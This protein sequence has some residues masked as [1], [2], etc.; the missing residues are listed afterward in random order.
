VYG[1]VP[2]FGMVHEVVGRLYVA[3]IL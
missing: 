2:L 1:K 3:L